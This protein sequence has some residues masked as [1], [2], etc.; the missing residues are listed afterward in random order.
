MQVFAQTV[1]SNKFLTEPREQHCPQQ[2]LEHTQMQ[3]SIEIW[4]LKLRKM[5]SRKNPKPKRRQS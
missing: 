1:D 5:Y 3:I 2:I 4:V